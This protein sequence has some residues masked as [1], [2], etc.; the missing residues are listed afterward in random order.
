[1]PSLQIRRGAAPQPL[2]DWLP[3][4]QAP[5][6]GWAQLLVHPAG[7]RV[8]AEQTLVERFVREREESG[9]EDGHLTTLALVRALATAAVPA[10]WHT[11]VDARW[12]WR[13]VLSSVGEVRASPQSREAHDDVIV[14]ETMGTPPTSG[15]C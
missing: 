15:A 10:S 7:T 4:L 12:Q 9:D 2:G 1:V 11:A 14:C 8:L 3:A 5:T 13:I 6:R